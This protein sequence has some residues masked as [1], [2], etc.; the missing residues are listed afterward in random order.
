MKIKKIL[1]LFL[2]I[3][4]FTGCNIKEPPTEPELTFAQKSEQR[5]VINEGKTDLPLLTQKAKSGKPVTVLYLG[6]AISAGK[7]LKENEKSFA[8]LS[9][10]EIKNL[11]GGGKNIGYV[12]LS[13]EN[14]TPSIA[15]AKFKNE[16]QKIQPDIV[17]LEFDLSGKI[18][19][20]ERIAFENLIRF[21]LKTNSNPS[22]ILVLTCKKSNI[23]SSDLAV[24]IAEY[25]GLPL[26][27]IPAA[28]MP[29][30]A[31]GRENVN[32]F[33][34]E[35]E[36]FS[37]YGHK[38]TSNFILKAFKNILE[39]NQNYVKEN[40]PVAMYPGAENF[41]ISF[42]P[43]KDFFIYEKGSF[44]KDENDCFDHKF[45]TGE[46]PL[47]IRVKSDKLFLYS[48]KHSLGKNTYVEF[49]VNDK[50][51][52]RKADE[53]FS[54]DIFFEKFF[55]TDKVKDLLVKI[56]VISPGES[57]EFNVCGLGISEKGEEK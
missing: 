48:E 53:D 41:D 10:S 52:L 4:F 9:F 40:L 42:L 57:T 50:I 23:T 11:F 33:F 38:M 5:A 47:E 37:A 32:N 31:T 25:Y 43:A 29:E 21:L 18:S 24:K 2:L 34:G 44:E 28:M 51:V 39:K 12:N 35:G 26:I 45:A 3:T 8:E 14:I 13:E 6:G 7:D 36:Y 27:G 22:V 16:L 20:D 54:K 1:P 56:R 19:Q 55:E 46:K 30:W 17:F 49:N 15:V